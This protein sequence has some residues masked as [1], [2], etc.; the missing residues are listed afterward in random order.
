[1]LDTDQSAITADVYYSDPEKERFYV[2]IAFPDSGMYINSFS[3]MPSKFEGEKYWV[4]PPKFRKKGGWGE[5]VEFNKSSYLWSVIEQKARNA[6]EEF[7]KVQPESS[8]K[9]TIVEDIPDGPITL[10]DIP[11]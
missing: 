1:M 3:V 9:D 4:Q 7:K 2:R 5:Y 10:D 11:F 8:T 6:V